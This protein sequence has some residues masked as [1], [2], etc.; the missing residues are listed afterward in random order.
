MNTSAGV[1]ANDPFFSGLP[2]VP[3]LPRSASK[4]VRDGA[5]R[6][7]FDA[8]RRLAEA[9]RK[10]AQLL[11]DITQ[12]IAQAKEAGYQDGRR[13]ADRI[14]ASELARVERQARE[15][16]DEA[17]HTIADLAVRIAARI[18]GKHT[19]EPLLLSTVRQAIAEHGQD[20]PYWIQVAAGTRK[21]AEDALAQLRRENPA[22]KLPMV[23]IDARLPEGR[24]I[25]V[26]RFGTVDLDI[27]SQLRAIRDSLTAGK[28]EKT[29]IAL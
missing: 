20:H 10:S 12:T 19:Q 5:A 9:E 15:F 18:I 2:V 28:V 21:A 24:A 14:L 1:D 25:L 26:T 8:E 6:K 11:D 17:S 13:E 27:E 22:A 23:R 29:S 3:P 4:I 7:Q 16:Y